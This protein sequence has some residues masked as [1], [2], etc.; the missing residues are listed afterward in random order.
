MQLEM[1]YYAILK[2]ALGP[3]CLHVL[4]GYTYTIVWCDFEALAVSPPFIFS[5]FLLQTTIAP[6]SMWTEIPGS[7][8]Y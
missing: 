4:Q 6:C 1:L 5:P 7:P 3:Y 2:M 8:Q